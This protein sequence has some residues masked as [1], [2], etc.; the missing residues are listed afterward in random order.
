MFGVEQQCSCTM[1]LLRI[2]SYLHQLC[3]VEQEMGP[4]LGVMCITK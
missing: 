2:G 3:R 4:R 1:E